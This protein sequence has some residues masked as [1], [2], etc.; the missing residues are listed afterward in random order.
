MKIPVARTKRKTRSRAVRFQLAIALV[1]GLSA[2]AP[3]TSTTSTE[4]LNFSG[5]VNWAALPWTRDA[6]D[7]TPVPG[8][9]DRQAEAAADVFFIHPTTYLS[10][11]GWNATTDDER[12]NNL[13]GWG[14]IRLQA[15]VFND[16]CRV[17]APRY[18]QAALRSFMSRSQGGRNALEMAYEDVRDAFRYYLAHFDEGRPLIIAA[19]S[20]GSFHAIRLLAEFFDK[21]PALR[22]R[23]VAAYVI[24]WPVPCGAFA[25]IPPCDRADQTGCFVSW[26][27]YIWGASESGRH[28]NRE[29]CCINPLTWRRDG[30]YAPR[31]LN[32]GGTPYK[33]DRLDPGVTD[34]QCV[35][36]KLWVHKPEQSG[37]VPLGKSMHLMD[38]NLFYANIRRNAE[39]RL[40]AFRRQ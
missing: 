24:G 28:S 38:Y 17:F 21:D 20:Q 19:H 2:C 23:L 13:T 10:M 6:A 11:F 27:T 32:L 22:R 9:R 26:S 12:L 34:A 1:A 35:D 31:E 5:P 36:G 39:T 7:E 29:G 18:R 8:L 30:D 4:P 14:P 16:C 37:Y 33:F 3:G 25:N 40:S 15:S